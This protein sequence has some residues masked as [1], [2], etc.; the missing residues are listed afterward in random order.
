MKNFSVLPYAILVVLILNTFVF[1][2]AQQ[3]QPIINA[4]LIGTV[5]DATTKEPIEG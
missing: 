3:P 1:A 2:E 5:I 4:S